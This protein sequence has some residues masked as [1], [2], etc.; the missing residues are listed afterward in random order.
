[1]KIPPGHRKI[2]GVGEYPRPSSGATP[3]VQRRFTHREIFKG[4]LYKKNSGIEPLLPLD[5]DIKNRHNMLG[6]TEA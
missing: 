6:K 3:A 1:M 5:K 2:Q 4:F